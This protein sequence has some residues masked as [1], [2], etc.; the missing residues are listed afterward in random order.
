MANQGSDLVWLEAFSPIKEIALSSSFT[1]AKAVTEVR[2]SARMEASS[3]RIS[4][5]R[6]EVNLS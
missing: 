1:T 4:L 5:L 3:E 2:E 6:E